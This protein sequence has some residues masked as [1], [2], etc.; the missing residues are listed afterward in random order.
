MERK[1]IKKMI[2]NG[3]MVVGMTCQLLDPVSAEIAAWAGLCSSGGRTHS[4]GFVC[5]D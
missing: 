4:F 3:E 5:G 2:A 1:N